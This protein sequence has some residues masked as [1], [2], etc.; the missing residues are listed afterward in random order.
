MRNILLPVDGTMRSDAAVQS[1]IRQAR[2]GEIGTI[3]LMTVQPQLG[4]YIGRFLK[5]V[6]VRDF[7]R[8]QGEKA[9]SR[10]K[11]LLD[12]AGIAY[13]PHI[14]VGNMVETI[15]RAAKQLGVDEIVM[16]ANNLGLVGSLDLH[17]VVGRVLRGVNVPVS[18]VNYPAT[19]MAIEAPT[20]ASWQL[21]PTP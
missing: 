21:R 20:A 9:L 3:H 11:R 17:S 5:T 15:V 14:Y 19:D 6:L 12:E 10:A 2:L 1:V 7:Q 16:S 4:S 18:V 13:Q 8:E